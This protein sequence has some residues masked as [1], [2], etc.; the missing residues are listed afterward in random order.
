MLFNEIPQ[1]LPGKHV[2]ESNCINPPD[3]EWVEEA[4]V[5]PQARTYQVRR[6][7]QIHPRGCSSLTY[8]QRLVRR[9]RVH[10]ATEIVKQD[11]Y[12]HVPV[13]LAKEHIRPTIIL[14]GTQ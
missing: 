9:P 10:N 12:W 13:D 2:R 1:T 14:V 4:T 3:L 8:R 7:L 5:G 11:L 6:A